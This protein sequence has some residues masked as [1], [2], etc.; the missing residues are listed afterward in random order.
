[1]NQ[2][3]TKLN[4]NIGDLVEVLYQ[5]DHCSYGVVLEITEFKSTKSRNHAIS[6]MAKILFDDG[7]RMQ[8]AVWCKLVQKLIA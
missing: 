4:L 2:A 7:I 8:P 3:N 1:M 5:P 6:I